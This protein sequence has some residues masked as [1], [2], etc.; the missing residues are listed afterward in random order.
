M[1]TK[2]LILI[3]LGFV[4]LP[5]CLEDFATPDTDALLTEKVALLETGTIINTTM[6]SK[7]LEGNLLGDPADRPVYVYLPKS[8]YA[9]PDKHFPVIYFLHGMPA[10]GKMMMEPAPFEIFKQVANLQASVDYPGVEFEDWVNDLIDSKGMKEAIIVFPDARTLFGVSSYTNSKVLGKCEDYIC[11]DLVKFIDSNFRTIDHFNWR[12]ITGHCAGG[13]G[14]LKL[15]M[16]HPDIFRYAA[17]LSPA[18]FP[19]ETLMAMASMMPVED[20]MWEPM[21][22]PSGPI[23]YDPMQPFKFVNNSVYFLMQ[24]WLPNP[25]NPPY[26]AD[27]PFTFVDGV[28][29]MNEDLMKKTDQQNLMALSSKYRTGLKKLK[30]V[31]FDCGM[32]DDLMMYPPNEMFH[33]HL[34][35]MHIKHQFETYDNP[36]THISNLYE[37]LG[38]TLVMLSNDFPD[39]E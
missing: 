14:A 27:L 25:A 17:G 39:Y 24:A 22:A 21:G 29:V 2:I 38:K 10:W 23:P 5:A 31:Y 33:Q 1:K 12:A 34:N 4:I 16:K 18:H 28:P 13:Y 32:N 36:G 35:E 15:A 3:L 26:L 8:Y 6:H 11:K 9:C 30:T 19:R 7:A 20:Q 37:R